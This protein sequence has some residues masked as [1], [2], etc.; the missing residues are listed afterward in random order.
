MVKLF[1]D[2]HV[3]NLRITWLIIGHASFIIYA[4]AKIIRKYTINYIYFLKDVIKWNNSTNL[5][6]LCET[7]L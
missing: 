2:S 6:E 3:I 7:W 4:Y 1:D 5:C